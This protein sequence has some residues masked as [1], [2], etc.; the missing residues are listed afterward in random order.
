MD[1]IN[2]IIWYGTRE[3]DTVPPHFIKASTKITDESYFWVKTVLTGRF[4]VHTSAISSLES[5]FDL[6]AYIFFED[7]KEVM[8]YELRWAGSK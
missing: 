6:N 3:L 7:P 4:S 8:L 5:I 1:K 2:P